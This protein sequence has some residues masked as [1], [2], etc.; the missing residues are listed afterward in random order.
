MPHPT[1]RAIGA[2]AALAFAVGATT[3]CS[4]DKA[5]RAEHDLAEQAKKD[6][7]TIEQ[8]RFLKEAI[9]EPNAAYNPPP[10]ALRR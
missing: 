4:Q 6:G 9:G 8:E 10:Y 5:S 2:T 7:L 3:A 1:L